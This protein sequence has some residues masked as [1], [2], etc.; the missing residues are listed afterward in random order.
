MFYHCLIAI[1]LWISVNYIY[2][3]WATTDD[4]DGDDGNG[5]CGDGDLTTSLILELGGG[6]T[7]IAFAMPSPHDSD[8]NREHFH[9]VSLNGHVSRIYTH[10][11]LGYGRN[12]ARRRLSEHPTAYHSCAQGTFDRCAEA[13]RE[14]FFAS[15]CTGTSC[16][17]DGVYQPNLN[18][19]TGPMFIFSYFYDHIGGVLAPRDEKCDDVQYIVTVDDFRQIAEFACDGVASAALHLVAKFG[20]LVHK[21]LLGLRERTGNSSHCFDFTYQYLLLADGYKIPSDRNLIAAK[22]FED[23]EASWT[24]GAAISLVEES[25]MA[26]KHAY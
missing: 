16:G 20:D 25:L 21:R 3:A 15:E 12:E 10:S 17:I 14:L 23:I 4:D 13:V 26:N 24:L 2:D 19:F 22:T 1:N 18:E 9:N 5:V 6:S 8:G 7:Q 11:Y